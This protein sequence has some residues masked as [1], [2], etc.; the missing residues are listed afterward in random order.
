MVRIAVFASGEG[1]NAMQLIRHFNQD[2][3]PGQVTL[4]V[5]NNHN[6]PVIQK[7]EESG[8]M[9]QRITPKGDNGEEI[10]KLLRQERIGFIVLAGYLKLI[11]PS[12]ISEYNKRIINV[13]PSLLP[14]FGGKGMYGMKVHEAVIAAGKNESGATVHY[15]DHNFDEG[16]VVARGLVPI[17]AEDTPITLMNKVRKVELELLP[18][19]TEK[20][21]ASLAVSPS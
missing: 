3:M 16:E 17:D 5:T 6:A 11:P 10:L 12:V 20:L 15:V 1:T 8:V 13:H 14:E 19:V 18:E 21:V 9:V 4:I 7:A 2:G